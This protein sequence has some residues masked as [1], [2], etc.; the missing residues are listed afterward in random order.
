MNF[1]T[2]GAI[3]QSLD[4]DPTAG[5]QILG[6][7]HLAAQYHPQIEP[8]LPLLIADLHGELDDK[9]S[10]LGSLVQTLQNCYPPTHKAILVQLSDSQ[11]IQ[12]N[13]KSLSEI[14]TATPVTKD[15]YLYLPGVEAGGSFTAL[16][17]VVAH[18]RA[19]D[20]C[21][22]DREQS[23][24]T[25][26]HDLL[27]EAAEVL[28]AI[29]V[30][31]DGTDNTRH[32]VEEL[33]DLLLLPSM[34]TQIAVDEARFQMADVT[35][36]IVE[37]LIRR[38]PHV[39]GNVDTDDVDEIVTNW[40]AIKAQEKAERGEQPRGP[41]DGIPASLP[42]LE[43]ARKIQSKA[44][45]AGLLNRSE[46]AQSANHLWTDLI[47]QFDSKQLN[48]TK[49]GAFLWSLVA[50]AHE[51]DLNT[52]DALRSHIVNYRQRHQRSDR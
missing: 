3:V 41:L 18:L 23:L 8:T 24:A 36:G 22:W 40:D 38:H 7:P 31:A 13:P 48:E 49:L 4:I 1:S 28:E 14:S 29:D 46:L 21:P 33:G 52:E 50:L 35:R 11:T 47:E 43:K 27:D 9:G 5:L 44:K 34:M 15:S 16:L 30:E 12:H 10:I 51:A 19:P 39:F 45:K 20:G 42:A 26:R 32:I 2:I 25:L 6:A 37:K 17:N